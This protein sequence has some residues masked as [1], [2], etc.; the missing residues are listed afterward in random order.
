MRQ[1]INKSVNAINVQLD[2]ESRTHFKQVLPPTDL[3]PP[4]LPIPP[5]EPDVAEPD[6]LF[7]FATPIS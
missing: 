3:C 1:T 7:A 2:V 4:A 6:A 5:F